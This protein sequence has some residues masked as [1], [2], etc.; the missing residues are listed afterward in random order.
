MK[1]GRFAI[2]MIGITLAVAALSWAFFIKAMP[3]SK[4]V[5]YLEKNTQANNDEAAKMGAANKRVQTAKDMVEKKAKEWS[6][7]VATKTPGTSLATGGIDLS[8]NPWQLVVDLPKF[9][10]SVQRAI[11]IQVKKGGVK[12]INAPEVPVQTDIPAN[13]VLLTAFN[14]PAIP[15]PVVV[16]DFGAITVQGTYQ[17]I[18]D[19]VRAYKNMPHYLA[20][21]DG[22]RIDGTSPNLTGTYNLSV[23]GFIRAK[24]IA[25]QVNEG[26]A[27]S[28][29]G[30]GGAPGF[31]GFP[32][33]RGGAPGGGGPPAGMSGVPGASGGAGI[34]GRAGA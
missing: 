22:L 24:K 21:A 7:T 20:V 31:G 2:L 27:Q 15:F 23:V 33:G 12:V 34:P 3:N 17:Q 13:Q 32:G 4:E 14:Y 19:N 28:A 10:D 18:M 16:Y 6:A 11:N 5:S 26:V 8:V 1:L 30:G 9:R 29:A 25:A